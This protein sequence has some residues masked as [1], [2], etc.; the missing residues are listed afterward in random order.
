MGLT[1]SQL[2]SVPNMPSLFP[3]MVKEGVMDTILK[4]LAEDLKRRDKLDLL[5]CYIDATLARAKRG[6][7]TL[8]L[9]KSGK[10]PR[11]W[12]TAM[13]FLLPF[14]PQFDPRGGGGGM[15]RTVF[16][17]EGLT[18]QLFFIACCGRELQGRY[19]PLRARPRSARKAVRFA[20]PP[21]FQSHFL[22]AQ[23]HA[24]GSNRRLRHHVARRTLHLR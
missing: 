15:K 3:E 16:H 22:L 17:R 11:S 6:V 12:Q 8:D 19:S 18:P 23:F 1:P 14:G 20:F 13:A 10:G 4:A 9:R 2:S 24:S 7:R 21:A 5:E